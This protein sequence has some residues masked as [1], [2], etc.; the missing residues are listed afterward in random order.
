M[1]SVLV[2]CFMMLVAL[3]AAADDGAATSLLQRD[4]V[5]AS[6]D[7]GSERAGNQFISAA[8]KALVPGERPV[9]ANPRKLRTTA[10]PQ[11]MADCETAANTCYEWCDLEPPGGR[12]T[13]MTEC[14]YAH[15]ACNCGCGDTSS[16]L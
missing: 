3:S 14:F 4:E 13:C 5:C 2:A 9:P 16:C 7:P 10:D 12:A 15:L 8:L 6:I 11:C 1:K